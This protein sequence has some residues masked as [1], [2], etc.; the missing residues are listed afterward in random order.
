MLQQN[1]FA[2]SKFEMFEDYGDVQSFY[3]TETKKYLC[4]NGR[5]RSE[6]K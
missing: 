5:I 2:D 3:D 6:G 4:R 1:W